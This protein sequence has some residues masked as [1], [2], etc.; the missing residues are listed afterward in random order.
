M[1]E[2]DNLVF[3]SL[4]KKA[5]RAF[6]TPILSHLAEQGSDPFKILIACVL[7][8]RTRDQVTAEASQRLFAISSDP[9]SMAKMQVK[10]IEKTIFPVA[11]F[12]IKARQIKGISQKI[13]NDFHGKA[14][15][16][17]DALLSLPGVGRKTA[18]LVVTLAYKKPGICVDTHVH[19]ICNRW[20]FV[21]TATPD[22][23]EQALRGKLP[24][25]WWIPLN[26]MLVPFGQNIC[27]PVSPRCSVCIL[28]QCCPKNGVLSIR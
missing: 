1:N 15:D 12:R 25:R 19:R 21:F 27:T 22:E 13:C 11:F 23:T 16:T 6:P 7:S 24:R 5:I 28:G 4:V 2:D 20:G 18:N 10:K 8:L 3:L 14:P 9:F 26:G 17:I